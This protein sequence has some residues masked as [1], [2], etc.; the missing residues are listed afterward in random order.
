MGLGGDKRGLKTVADA[1]ALDKE[2]SSDGGD[3][4]R[5]RKQAGQGRAERPKA[6][7]EPEELAVAA[8]ARD[9]LA[10]GDGGEGLANDDGDLEGGG[11]EGGEAADGLEVDG[12][13]I[14]DA[15]VDY[16]VEEVLGQDGGD[17]RGAEEA[18]CKRGGRPPLSMLGT[19][20]GIGQ[21]E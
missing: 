5:A 18:D 9:I 7:A 16:A 21:W 20:A 10:R 4:D 19:R 13:I 6:V 14:E 12:E 11:G 15:I 8:V 3:R 2:D 1:D 17:G